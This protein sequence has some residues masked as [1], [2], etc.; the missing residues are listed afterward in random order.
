MNMRTT[1]AAAISTVIAATVVAVLVVLVSLGLAPVP[2]LRRGAPITL[3]VLGLGCVLLLITSCWLIAATHPVPAIGLSLVALAW[4]LPG[5]AAWPLPSAQVRA[6]LL[7]AQPLAVAGCA[8]VTS[9]WR[10]MPV[11][12][13]ASTLAT[14]GSATTAAAVLLVGYDPFYD[15]GCRRTC[16]ASRAIA[17]PVLGTEQAFAISLVI[18]VAAAVAVVVLA[19]RQP[20]APWAVRAA[21]AMA[22]MLGASAAYSHWWRW[23]HPGAA[24][25][26]TRLQ[27]LGALLIASA[28]LLTAVHTLMI[29][30]NARDIVN[31]LT[32]ELV[33]GADGLVTAVHFAIPDNDGWVDAEGQ[34]VSRD[35]FSRCAILSDGEGPAVCLVLSRSAD[36][37]QVLAAVRPA[38]RLALENAR[39]RAAGLVKL[40]EV[41]ASQR[42]IVEIA[43]LERQRIERDLHDGAQQRLVAAA[44]HLSSGRT[45]S[46]GTPSQHVAAGEAHLLGALAALREL[47]HESPAA[48]LGVDGLVPAVEELVTMSPVHADLDVTITTELP[49]EVQLAAY[50]TIVAALDNVATHA[51]V[52]RA[53]IMLHEQVDQLLIRITDNGCGGA[54]I[55]PGLTGIAD[56]I[57]ALGGDLDLTSRS[58]QGTSVTVRLP[59]GS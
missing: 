44:M 53:R 12:L 10:S 28:I 30:R 13:G 51:G 49:S 3:S 8:L 32:G 40:L 50:F 24:A 59:C 27:T 37:A 39:I 54:T 48:D 52:H 14:I 6:A 46:K 36:P 45:R 31:Q 2:P 56:R 25:I 43:D 7:A 22:A 17:S 35:G 23:R 4:L 33:D 47:S 26:E 58:G 57:G 5:L 19:V 34:R 29:R 41:Q 11:R 18:T 42:R 21:A 1:I 20:G 9:G 15:P 55:G 38:Q 16:L